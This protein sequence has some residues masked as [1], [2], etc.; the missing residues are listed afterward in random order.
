MRLQLNLV[1]LLPMMMPL[2]SLC[3]MPSCS[4]E[5]TDS[6]FGRSK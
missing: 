3:T 1:L 2:P 6:L 5:R 4:G